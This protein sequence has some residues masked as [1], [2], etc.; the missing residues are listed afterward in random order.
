MELGLPVT[1]A[2]VDELSAH[3][4]DIDFEAVA[5]RERAG[6]SVRR[7]RAEARKQA[8]AP[9]GRLHLAAARKPAQPLP[10]RGAHNRA[11]PRSWAVRTPAAELH[12]PEWKETPEERKAEL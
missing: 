10:A 11:A 4:D 9:V 3:T 2:Q 5:E 1:Q 12:R 7:R 6:A 8:D